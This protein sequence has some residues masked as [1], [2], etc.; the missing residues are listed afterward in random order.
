LRLFFRTKIFDIYIFLSIY[1]KWRKYVDPGF[2]LYL[3]ISHHEGPTIEHGAKSAIGISTLFSQTK[4]LEDIGEKWSLFINL[5][6]EYSFFEDK[7]S[8]R[9]DLPSAFIKQKFLF[10]D[11]TTTLKFT[12]RNFKN[13]EPTFL[14]ISEFPTGQNYAT[15]GHFAVMPGFAFEY[16]IHR[17]YHFHIHGFLSPRFAL[18]GE[19]NTTSDSSETDEHNHIH[20]NSIH[21]HSHTSGVHKINYAFPHSVKE[22]M[23]HI[24]LM[25]MFSEIGFDLRP[26][27]FLEDF[28]NFV[29][30][31]Q[32]GL[33]YISELGDG[34][35]LNFNLFGFWALQGVR[36]GK[37]V[38]L[39]SYLKF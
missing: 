37:G 1:I 23:G 28:K 36:E 11:I 38:G 39:F 19:S 22:L 6:G 33:I 5:F 20:T 14:F 4:I 3:F 34:K 30:Q 16:H 8:F 35:S 13:F 2:F 24:G 21:S 29:F 18:G 26:S 32:V 9:L 31:P 27:F 25:V 7:F 12:V 10:S 15:A 17:P